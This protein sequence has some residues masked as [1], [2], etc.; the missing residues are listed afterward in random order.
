MFKKKINQEDLIKVMQEMIETVNSAIQKLGY[1]T[2][3][4]KNSIDTQN[5]LLTKSMKKTKKETKKND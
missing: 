4:L 2:L 3:E 5:E 1:V